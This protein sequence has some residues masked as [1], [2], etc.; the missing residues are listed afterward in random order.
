MKKLLAISLALL[1]SGFLNAQG[2]LQFDRILFEQLTSHNGYDHV[3][4]IIVPDNQ[5]LKLTSATSSRNSSC[6]LQYKKSA[7]PNDYYI[8]IS[9]NQSGYDA[10]GFPLWLPTGAY[11]IRLLNTCNSC[12]FSGAISGIFFNVIP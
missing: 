7:L 9:F 10:G 5:V 1:F 4:D 3:I 6:A 2:T 12:E 11:N 8:D